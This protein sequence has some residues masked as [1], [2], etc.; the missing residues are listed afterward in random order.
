M[1]IVLCVIVAPET[2]TSFLRGSHNNIKMLNLNSIGDKQ[3]KYDKKIANNI[4]EQ[5]VCFRPIDVLL[6]FH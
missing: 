5:H 1:Y 2:K 4:V 6:I 3:D